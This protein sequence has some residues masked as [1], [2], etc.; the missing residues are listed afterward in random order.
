MNRQSYDDR[1]FG[2]ADL[3][4]EKVLTDNNENSSRLKK[5]LLDVISGELTERQREIVI[6]YYFKGKNTVEIAEQY[7]ITP[8]AVSGVLGRAKRRMC[9]ILKYYV[10]R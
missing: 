1:F 5:I 6:L 3:E 7:G 2:A 10:R 9:R 8:Q 4:I